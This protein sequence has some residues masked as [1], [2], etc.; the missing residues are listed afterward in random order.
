MRNKTNSIMGNKTINRRITKSS[1]NRSMCIN[2][3][4]K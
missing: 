4:K 2:I 1:M 3:Q